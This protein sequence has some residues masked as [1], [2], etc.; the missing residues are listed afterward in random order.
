MRL[1]ACEEKAVS[2]R[3]SP[4]MVK[5]GLTDLSGGQIQLVVWDN[6]HVK[7]FLTYAECILGELM[8]DF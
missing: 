4:R 8:K 1:L 3:V 2:L 7:G 6:E 5:V